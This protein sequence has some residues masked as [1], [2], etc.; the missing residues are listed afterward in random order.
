MS[1]VH[2]CLSQL[3]V[4]LRPISAL[5][6]CNNADKKCV[7]C[8]FKSRSSHCFQWLIL[9]NRMEMWKTLC[10]C[11]HLT[12]FYCQ[13]AAPAWSVKKKVRHVEWAYTTRRNI[14]IMW[15]YVAQHANVRLVIGMAPCYNTFMLT[16]WASSPAVLL[17]FWVDCYTGTWVVLVFCRHC[18]RPVWIHSP[19]HEK[20]HSEKSYQIRSRRNRR[21]W[22]ALPQT[23]SSKRQGTWKQGCMEAS[24]W[25]H[26]TRHWSCGLGHLRQS[27]NTWHSTS[28]QITFCL[29]WIDCHNR[30]TQVIQFLEPC[31]LT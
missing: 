31:I 23:A 12:S 3:C 4:K 20:L 8:S 9:T 25:L 11:L 17:W 13:S 26:F 2:R 14:S 6:F 1:V 21:N 27:Q 22:R 5:T 18:F 7:S 30:W 24:H 15:C 10:I 16:Y 29:E 28:H 19:A